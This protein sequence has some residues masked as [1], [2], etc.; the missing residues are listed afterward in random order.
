[1]IISM[2]LMELVFG[3]S[4]LNFKVFIVLFSPKWNIKSKKGFLEFVN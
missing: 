4:H 2:H 1:M 3:P